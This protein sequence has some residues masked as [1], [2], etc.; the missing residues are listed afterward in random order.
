MAKN[1]KNTFL[2]ICVPFLNQ[3]LTKNVRERNYREKIDSRNNL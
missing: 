1:L 2:K 3:N